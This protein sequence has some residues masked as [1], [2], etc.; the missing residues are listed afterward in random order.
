MNELIINSANTNLIVLLNCDGKI[1]FKNEASQKKHNEIILSLIDELLK[2]NNLKLKDID[3]FG[4]VVG[5]G[6]FTGIRVGIA[7]IKAFRDALN[8]PAKGINNLDFL[9]ELGRHKGL[10]VFAIE[11]SLNSFFV[12]EVVGDKLYIHNKNL[13]EDELYKIAN[14][15][16]VGVFE[17]GDR[18]KNSRIDFEELEFEPKALVEVLHDKGDD[19]LVPIYYQLSQA[20]EEKINR[21]NLEIIKAEASDLEEIS[22]IELENFS[23]GTTGEMPME[24]NM[25]RKVLASDMPNFVAKL[26]GV[27]VGYL[28]LEKTDEI[29]ISRIAVKKDY[30]NH[31]MATKMINYAIRLAKDEGINL[32]LEVSENN[33][34]ALRLYEKVGFALRR[35]RKNYYHDGS[36]CMEMSLKVN[37]SHQ[38]GH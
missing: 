6:S 14:G 10:E 13:L 28:F 8:I 4:V 38:E 17:L 36:D 37:D 5:P 33:T 26:D 2:E 32:S 30:Q 20:E 12:A 29:N 3:K 9:C 27:L 11:G 34:R 15:R 24:S 1:S 16:K 22:K 7:T 31:G 35:K 23:D 25:L 21:G 19:R 18:L